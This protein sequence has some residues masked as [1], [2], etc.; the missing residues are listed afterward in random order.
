MFCQRYIHGSK[1]SAH[2]I[3]WTNTPN[4]VRIF[5]P[6]GNKMTSLV[7]FLQSPYRGIR[8]WLRKNRYS[9][10]PVALQRDTSQQCGDWVA[11]RIVMHHLSDQRFVQ[12]V[13]SSHVDRESLIS[14]L[15]AVPLMKTSRYCLFCNRLEHER[16]RWGVR[17]RLASLLL[18]R[19]HIRKP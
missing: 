9:E 17:M 8:E 10:R 2:W 7:N 19:R 15:C 11:L 4:G 18:L 12:F 13:N 1:Y 5:D 14:L 6:L 3:L 16:H